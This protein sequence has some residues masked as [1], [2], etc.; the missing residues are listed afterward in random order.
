MPRITVN[1][2]SIEAM[3]GA[4]LL[5]SAQR[6][7]IPIPALCHDPRVKPYGGCRLC[8]VEIDGQERPV[9]SCNTVVREGM[10][11]RTHTPQ[12]E[13]LRKTLLQLLACHYPADA[14]SSQPDKP[15]HEL[16]RTY[17]VTP[18][19]NGSKRDAADTSHPYIHVNPT[20]CILCYRCV[21]IC[22][23][24]QGQFVWQVWNRGDRSR[25]L[26][27]CSASPATPETGGRGL[28]QSACV[29]CGACVD[30]CPTG[31]LEDKTLLGVRS[32]GLQ[33]TRTTCPYCGTGCEMNVGTKDGQ[34]L[35]CKPVLDA[36][37]SKGHLCSKGR[38][39]FG[40]VHAPDRVLRPM[41]RNRGQWQ[42]ASW[43]EAI[44]ATADLIRRTVERHGPESVGMLGSARATNEENYVTQKFVRVVLGTNNV[45]CCARVCH[46]PTAE[47]MKQTLGTGAATNSYDDI[48]RAGAILVCG[49][50][51]TEAHPVIG[52]RV[53]Q[54]ALRGA[55]LI[56]IDPRKIELC[57]FADV[58]L[59]L[60]PGTN[61]PL[62]NAMACTII[63]EELTDAQYVR[64]RIDGYEQFEQ[65]IRRFS[66]EAVAEVCGVPAS[67]IRKAAR[68]YATSKP[69]LSLHGLGMT[70]HVQGTD[71][72]MCLV[73]LALLT[74]NMGK[75]GTGVNPLRGQN[76]VQGSAHMGCDPGVLTGG[77]A[78][79]TGAERFRNILGIEPPRKKGLNLIEM[80]EAA[81]DSQLKLLWTIGYDILISNAN[82]AAT[83][84][85]LKNLDGVIIQDMFIN[86]T[87]RELGTIFL[88][89]CSSF[90]KDG[91]FMNAERRVQRV[92]RA[93][94][95]LGDSK[96]DWEIVCAI[97]KQMGAGDQFKFESAEAIWNE[98]RKLWPAGAGMSYQRME[99]G[100]LQ[101][102]CPDEQHPGTTVLHAETFPIGK[103]AALPCIGFSPS[104]EKV[105]SE[106]PFLLITG[107]TLQQ[108]NAG[109][110]AQR[111]PHKKLRTTDFVDISPADAERLG[112]REGELVSIR[113][114]Y[115]TAMLPAH[116]TASVAEGELFA[117]F[118]D[119]RR[120]LNSVTGPFTD[121]QTLT[122]E[123]KVTAV[124]I[125]KVL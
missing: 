57:K 69:S 27:D 23:E 4:T 100:G 32:T 120:S 30:T 95:P 25:I 9:T 29:S 88:P 28:M 119:N 31:A 68:L 118:H 99:K 93:V 65:F 79:A 90:E 26:P 49:A 107:R 41:L 21:R 1:G 70:E 45:D 44:A 24:L 85:A 108:F 35:T 104:P 22:E 125:A 116:V 18:L 53:K 33:W 86:E 72:V 59:Q 122:P 62:L 87:A 3:P 42:T 83:R 48:E 19:S 91:T 103:R 75:P 51:P 14:I 40:F 6:A 34:I 76:N 46:G 80:M 105:A 43:D 60:R 89:A 37:V 101:W 54:A 10:T 78:I 92:R 96:T 8:L 47:A 98:V 110:M 109:T 2:R 117:T 13:A 12:I 63:E 106:Y 111:T 97:A 81:R 17:G 52:A 71:G 114:H 82:T 56:V 64:E 102:P 67:G 11:V 74:G 112:I 58:H 124:T 94:A 36:P 38:Y 115:G 121:K 5:E 66:P 61:V 15:F 73:N 55:H 84:S 113:S 39:A 123:Y 20:Q 16:L 77:V 7:G 50:N